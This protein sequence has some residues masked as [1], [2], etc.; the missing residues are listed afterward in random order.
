MS[1]KFK[2]EVTCPYCKEYLEVVLYSSVNVSIDP[3][4]REEVFNNKINTVECPKCKSGF[5]VHCQLMYHDMAK[6]FAVW[7]DPLNERTESKLTKTEMKMGETNYLFNAPV[8][9]TW[10]DFLGHIKLFESKIFNTPGSRRIMFKNLLDE[11]NEFIARNKLKVVCDSCNKED[12]L[13]G[14]S[15]KCISCNKSFENKQNSDILVFAIFIIKNYINDFESMDSIKNKKTLIEK[16]NNI[17]QFYKSHN[18]INKRKI[19]EIKAELC[20]NNSYGSL[21]YPALIVIENNIIKEVFINKD[22]NASEDIINTIPFVMGSLN[23][24]FKYKT[25][26]FS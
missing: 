12:E 5:P 2:A 1:N 17:L 3:T 9:N 23:Y 20:K 22:T 8:S 10:D 14:L 7:Y 16:L 13:F 25:G 21:G 6:Q 18:K 24:L 26:F 11:I 15:E 19:S 4:L